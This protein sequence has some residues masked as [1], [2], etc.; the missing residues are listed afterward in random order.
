[1]SGLDGG[2][3]NIAA[4]SLGAAQQCFEIALNYTKERKQFNQSLSSNQ[5]IQF[6]LADMASKIISSRA[7]LRQ[8]ALLL[9]Q[10][11]PA[12]SAHCA[13][14]KKVVTDNGFEVCNDALQLLGGYGKWTYVYI[15]W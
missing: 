14:A 5:S 6:K 8:A 11:H 2:R 1:M 13:I 4:C 3:L 9:D 7:L 15:V 10:S 12:A